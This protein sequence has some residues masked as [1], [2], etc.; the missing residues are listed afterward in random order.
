M[1]TQQALHYG[2]VEAFAGLG[3]ED[4]GKDEVFGCCLGRVARLHRFAELDRWSLF[5]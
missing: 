5:F 3:V 4:R 2:W 1:L